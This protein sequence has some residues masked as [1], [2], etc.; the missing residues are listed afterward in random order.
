MGLVK[1]GA[2]RFVSTWYQLTLETTVNKGGPKPAEK[3]ST[4]TRVRRN[5]CN[6]LAM[7]PGPKVFLLLFYPTAIYL[8]TGSSPKPLAPFTKLALLDKSVRS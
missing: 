5:N 6:R 8:Y 2:R 3:L 4:S 1:Y 7:S